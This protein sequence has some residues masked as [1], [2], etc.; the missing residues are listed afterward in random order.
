MA[1]I[2]DGKAISASE[3]ELIKEKVAGLSELGVV[4]CLAV[5]I[6][7]EDPAFYTL[8]DELFGK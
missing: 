5:I 8:L 2:I 1:E 4:P 3:R 6:V 7:G